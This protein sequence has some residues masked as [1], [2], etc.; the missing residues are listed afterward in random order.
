MLVKR[1]YETC[2]VFNT[3]LNSIFVSC[4]IKRNLM[5]LATFRLIFGTIHGFSSV[6]IYF[7]SFDTIFVYFYNCRHMFCPIGTHPI[8]IWVN[9]NRKIVNII[10]CA[11]T[12]PETELIFVSCQI[13]MN[14]MV[15][16]T[17]RLIFGLID[18]RTFIWFNTNRKIVIETRFARI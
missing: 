1:K 12:W 13:K 17:F 14:L 8:F 4:E 15:L 18:T 3:K 5:V 7:S 2:L 16:I 11:R 6:E 9:I 10:R